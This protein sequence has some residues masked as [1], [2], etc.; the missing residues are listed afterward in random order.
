LISELKEIWIYRKIISQLILLAFKTQF[1]QSIIG[2]FWHIIQPLVSSGVLVVVFKDILGTAQ[3]L[4]NPFLTFFSAIVFWNVFLQSFSCSAN[5][6]EHNRGIFSKIYFPRVIPVISNLGITFFR[7]ILQLVL[8]FIILLCTDTQLNPG[9]LL[10]IFAGSVLIF[11]HI[12][13]IGMGG[14]MIFASVSVIYKDMLISI[15]F[16]TNLLFFGSP[17]VYEISN[18]PPNIKR[19]VLLN[20]LS[21]PIQT[22]KELLQSNLNIDV[23]YLASF[24]IAC[25]I[26]IIGTFIFCRASKTFVDTI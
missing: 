22:A 18:L 9:D 8:Y 17:I 12:G 14:G 13:L 19:F 11:V 23:Q 26:F 3:D 1:R 25:I 4:E 7:F 2:P 20:P 15:P 5:V 10:I 21:T 24:G 6:L 16:L